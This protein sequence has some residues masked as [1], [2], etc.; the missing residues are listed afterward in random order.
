[1]ITIL[2]VTTIVC[3][4]LLIGTEFAVSVF[5]NPVLGQLESSAQAAAIRLFARKL[6]TAMPFWYVGCF[7]LLVVEAILRVHA[8]GF[9]FVVGA[10]VIWAAVIVLT[11][12]FLVPINNRMM[13]LEP[14]ALA[15][16]ARKEHR[17]WDRMHRVRVGALAIALVCF[18]IA[19]GV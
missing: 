6:G 5:I 9:G 14:G 18:L 15:V 13:R 10:S 2:N 17:R 12:L 3:V 4:G 1:M 8:Q 16:A 7:V 19:T 11:L